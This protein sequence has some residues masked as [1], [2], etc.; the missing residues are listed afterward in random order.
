MNVFQCTSFNELKI[1]LFSNVTSKAFES[2]DLSKI[3]LT[4]I[5]LSIDKRFFSILSTNDGG[6]EVNNEIFKEL[7]KSIQNVQHTQQQWFTTP[8][9]N[10]NVYYF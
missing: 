8:F 3:I 7:Q 4:S 1:R 6:L 2:N 9:L 10:C 5:V